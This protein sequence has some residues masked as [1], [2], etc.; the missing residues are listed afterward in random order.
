M[1][2][3]EIQVQGLGVRAPEAVP[4]ALVV[5][6]EIRAGVFFVKVEDGEGGGGEAQEGDPRGDAVGQVVGEDGF[7]HSGLA[8]QGDHGPLGEHAVDEPW[9]LSGGQGEDIRDRF[10]GHASKCSVKAS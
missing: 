6:D 2:E 3:V 9:G 8:G 1:V 10:A 4:D 5:F 7:A